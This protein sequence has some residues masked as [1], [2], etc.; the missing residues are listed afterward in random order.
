MERN[1]VDSAQ[2]VTDNIESVYRPERSEYPK[3][4]VIQQIATL[5]RF[6]KMREVAQEMGGDIGVTM[7][8]NSGEEYG[9]DHYSGLRVPQNSVY[10][11]IIHR[12]LCLS[13]FWEKVNS[14]KPQP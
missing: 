3:T 14:P 2:Q 9:T 13:D 6:Q 8:A 12:R 7:I 1:E 10:A 5:E 11:R 4:R